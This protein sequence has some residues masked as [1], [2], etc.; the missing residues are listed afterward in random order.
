[1][2]CTVDVNM[3]VGS[4]YQATVPEFIPSKATINFYFTVDIELGLIAYVNV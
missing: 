2:F 3:R 4:E 1:M